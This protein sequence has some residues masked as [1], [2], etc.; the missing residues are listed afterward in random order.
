MRFGNRGARGAMAFVRTW[1]ADQIARPTLHYLLALS[2][3]AFAVLASHYVLTSSLE[4]LDED[5]ELINTSG[6]QRMLSEQT[7]RL[8]GELMASQDA[9]LQ[10]FTYDQLGRSFELMQSS[11]QRL[12]EQ[13]RKSDG[14]TE[15]EH[16]LKETFFSGEAPLDTRLAEYFAATDQILSTDPALYNPNL[17]AYRRMVRA[18]N[19]GLLTDLN[20]V[21]AIYEDRS[22]ARLRASE[23]LHTNLLV[24]TLIL[25]LI[26]ALFIFHPL[27]RRLTHANGALAA[28]NSEMSRMIVSDM[29]TGLPNRKGF[30]ERLEQLACEQ[31]TPGRY[32]AVM[33]LDL[34]KFKNINDMYGHPVGDRILL[35]VGRRV[36]N[37]L[38]ENDTV[39]RLGGDE[40]ALI[41]RDLNAVSDIE[42]VANTVIETVGLPFDLGSL[43]LSIGVSIGIA[44]S[45]GK[46]VAPDELVTQADLAL[47]E[48]KRN[49]RGQYCVY[50]PSMQQEMNRK[51]GIAE[52]LRRAC[53]NDSLLVFLQPIVSFASGQVEYAE[54]L[55]RWH[56]PKRGLLPAAEFI[57]VVDEFQMAQ[58][59]EAIVYK[60]VFSTIS[61]WQAQDKTIPIVTL[62]VSAVNLRQTDFCERL[63]YAIK[64][65]GLQPNTFAIEI[66]ESVLVGRGSDTVIANI[67]N[68]SRLGFQIMLDDFGTGYASLSHLMEL[69]VD[70][71]KID[72]K[73]V[74]ESLGPG[75]PEQIV[76]AIL[77]L[78]DQLGITS[79]GE[80]IETLDQ[81][82]AI[83]AKGCDFGQGYLFSHPVSMDVF[84]ERLQSGDFELSAQ[85]AR[86]ERARLSRD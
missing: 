43:E 86:L 46:P 62:N 38:R 6:R 37:R 51:S 7:V 32:S 14:N 26:E 9:A 3:I 60:Q 42:K 76:T 44:V 81:M 19:Q 36:R 69:P 16:R 66:L 79:I 12:A 64:G 49:G 34:D 58:E 10:S 22:Q 29:L 5:A 85:L 70:A 25:L 13:V 15:F 27:I 2:L 59:I 57:D 40:F 39:A 8:A 82:D 20:N 84:D 83:R 77:A 28:R 78:A 68:L 73:F 30:A 35:E 72:K 63:M 18:H 41:V 47:N 45:D 71:I 21:V 80:G 54:S 67:R 52:D 17:D 4:E 33:M 56:H 24:G 65:Y 48:A 53:G 75:A 31:R 23:A 11:H 61:A 50:A 1:I 55:L 74:Q